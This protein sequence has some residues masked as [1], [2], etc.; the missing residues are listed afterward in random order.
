MEPVFWDQS[1]SPSLLSSETLGKYPDLL[2]PQSPHQ[3]NE[4]NN[5]DFTELLGGLNVL[6]SVKFLGQDITHSK[7]Y[8][9]LTYC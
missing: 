8:V 7:L 3:K 2:V 6:T 1:M 4:D 9:M 5:P